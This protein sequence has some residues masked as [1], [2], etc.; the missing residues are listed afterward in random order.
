MPKVI[1]TREQLQFLQKG[2]L[3]MAIGKLT[4][5]FNSR[6]GLDKTEGQIKST[7][8]N[9]KI[10]GGRAVKAG[11]RNDRRLLSIEQKSFVKEM[12]PFHS[13]ACVTAALN[14]RFGLAIKTS[15]LKTYVF[16]HGIKSGR[17]GCF[18]QGGQPWNTGTK[19]TGTCKP[20]SGTFRKGNVPGNI[21]PLG[22][23]RI[24]TK[25]GYVHVKVT[26]EN[27]YTGAKTRFKAKHVVVWEQHNGPVPKGMVVRLINGD[28]ENC[29]PENL[30]LVT[31]AEHLRLTQ[32]KFKEFPEEIKQ[33]V[34]AIAKL[35]VKTFSRKRELSQAP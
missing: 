9:H 35:D 18:V 20:N 3:W 28:P 14:R 19:G 32:L 12:Y 16:N 26:E 22:A 11:N 7:L 1:Y 13:V 15:Q 10:R 2:C 27:P 25:D 21:R 34:V 33:T 8:K 29:A 31:R 4:A 5:A 23:E 17:D 24:D 30:M 6:F